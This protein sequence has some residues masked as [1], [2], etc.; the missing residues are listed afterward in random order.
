MIEKCIF[1]ATIV[2]MGAVY[3]GKVEKTACYSFSVITL[4]AMMWGWW[5]NVVIVHMVDG[6][7]YFY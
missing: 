5:V 7:C 1:L 6:I 2:L 4:I 3:K